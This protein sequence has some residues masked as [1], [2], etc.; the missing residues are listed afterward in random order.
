MKN[1]DKQLV[2]TK[3]YLV[4]S[5]KLNLIEY[6]LLSS[7]YIDNSE[8]FNSMRL[9]KNLVESGYFEDI[10]ST[11]NLEYLLYITIYVNELTRI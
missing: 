3:K 6:F 4:N 10:T 8:L 1:Y 7:K 2:N 5:N 9:F 11:S